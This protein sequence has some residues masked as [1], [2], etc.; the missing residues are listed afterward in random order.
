VN[1][2]LRIGE[3]PPPTECFVEMCTRPA[4]ERGL[5]HAH[6][7]RVRRLGDTV[8][9]QPI[10]RRRNGVCSL[11]DCI[12]PAYARQLCRNHYRRLLRTGDP[13]A[14]VPI[15]EL[16]G[17]GFVSHGYRVVPVPPAL[18]HLVG[19]ATSA[20]EHRLVMSKMLGRPIRSDE[21]VHH[22][23][24]DRLDNRPENLELWSRWQ[25]SGQRLVDKLAHALELLRTYRPELLKDTT[26]E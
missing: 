26:L 2:E 10:S 4:T 3:K 5:C 12:R 16:P 22:L 13:Q 9:G 18:R 11:Q 20:L 1:D 15:K 25:P 21:S 8:A 24:G 6:Y 17:L 23:N 19:G 7:L 14:D